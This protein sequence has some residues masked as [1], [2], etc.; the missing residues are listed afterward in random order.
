MSEPMAIKPNQLLQVGEWQY[1]P[2]Q[3]KLMKFDA[4]GKLS[5]TA[6]LDNLCQ[7]VA[8]YFIVNA[9]KLVTKDEL[10]LDVW[11]IRD[12][13]DGRVTRVIRVL[14]VALGDDTREPRYIETIP[15]RGYRFIAPVS[16]IV[17]LAV[18]EDIELVLSPASTDTTPSRS[19]PLLV[20]GLAFAAVLIMALIW[21]LWPADNAATDDT[22]SAI[23]MW[24][25][26]PITALDGLE[27]YHNVSADERYLVYSYAAPD[28]NVVSVLMLQDLQEHKRAQLTDKSYNSFGAV[29]SPDGTKIAYQRYYQNEKCEIR[30]MSLSA[31]KMQVLDDNLLKYCGEKSVSIRISWSPDGRYIVYPNM[32]DV[33]KQMVLQMTSTD[34]TISEVLTVPPSSSFGD[35]AARFSRAG[36]QLV[37]LR[38]TAG[39]AQ[40]WL[41]NL[42]D[43]STR[44][45]TKV[46]DT[47]P[48]NV[49]WDL[50]DSSIIYPSASNALGRVWLDKGE[51][52]I[53]AY[54][55]AYASELQVT[56]SGK[57]VA[58]IGNFSRINP[59][60]VSNRITNNETHN[61]P[62]FS[63]NRNET[64]VEA[65]P[66]EDGPTAVVSR[67]SGSQ[68]VWLFYH[69]GSQKQLTN[70]SD[71]QRI[72]SLM[73]SPNGSRL[74]VQLNDEIWLFDIEG[75][76][77]KIAGEKDAVLAFPSW[78]KD[79]KSLFYSEARQGR[80][81]VIQRDI[82]DLGKREIFANDKEYYYESY[83]A[84]YAF[85]RSSRDKQFYIQRA[86][87][88]PQKLKI[89][90][91]ET[92]VMLRFE[93]RKT[94][95][96]YSYLV[97]ELNYRLSYLDFAAD[98]IINV[99]EPIQFGRFS[100]SA[101]EKFIFMLEYDFGDMDI[102]V[103]DNDVDV[104]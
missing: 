51:P 6:D 100:I 4:E 28:A 101:D 44:L 96:Y 25:Y 70:F 36:D 42:A 34:N 3:D 38:E 68:Q 86:G 97:D 84:D 15:K 82:N 31:D 24:R 63:S 69:D 45:L 7:K 22:A 77:L 103:I 87:E 14:R 59:K 93:L 85:W 43:R 79:G 64:F 74:M 50:T 88:Q 72:R 104:L 18:K 39:S 60:K 83:Y 58:S 32:D 40:I 62:V 17:P 65:N 89:E 78:S 21:W 95:I 61:E 12:V 49:D 8:N 30:L 29:F 48:G 19:K 53:L 67:R 56:T 102:A 10:L 35:Y 16:E 76:S 1:I 80:W 55:D 54:T 47:F 33:K 66:V 90:L 75:N 11:G 41:L 5:I 71:A 98:D 81:Q 37:F 94:G 46:P 91:P 73:F 57:I 13:S 23:P 9:G 20:S 26:T 52:T 2:E 92:Q 27:F 99:L